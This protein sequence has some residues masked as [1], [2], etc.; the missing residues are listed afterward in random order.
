M[1]GRSIKQVIAATSHMDPETEFVN[2]CFIP[3]IEIEENIS[4]SIAGSYFVHLQA[5]QFHGFL[6]NAILIA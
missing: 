4:G 5:R 1:V 3:T 2:T 6:L